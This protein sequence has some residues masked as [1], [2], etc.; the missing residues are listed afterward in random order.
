MKRQQEHIEGL[1]GTSARQEHRQQVLAEHDERDQRYTERRDSQHIIHHAETG[2]Q[3]TRKH[4][5]QSNQNA[6]RYEELEWIVEVTTE[7]V[8]TATALGHQP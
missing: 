8:I 4:G 3:H 5:A 1:F 7:E 6:N 2:N